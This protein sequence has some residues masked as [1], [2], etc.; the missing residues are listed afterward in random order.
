MNKLVEAY[1]AGAVNKVIPRRAQRPTSVLKHERIWLVVCKWCPH[2][3]ASHVM[4]HSTKH[5]DRPVCVDCMM[6]VEGAS[7]DTAYHELEG[8][9]NGVDP[10][11]RLIWSEMILQNVALDGL[12]YCTCGEPRSEHGKEPP[13]TIKRAI[14]ETGPDCDGYERDRRRN[15]VPQVRRGR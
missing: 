11:A 4:S 14:D 6:D 8:I 10:G 12:P 15:G 5:G 3:A 2:A 13:F 1:I 9:L 7:A